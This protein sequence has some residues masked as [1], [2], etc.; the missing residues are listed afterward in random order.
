MLHALIGPERS[1]HA[2]A[3]LFGLTEV[4]ASKHL[5]KLFDLGLLETRTAGRERF[6]S[7][8]IPG[9]KN[10]IREYDKVAEQMRKH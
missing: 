9:I 1:V 8:G 5:K 3:E 10:F 2:I 7:L 6:Y 4:T